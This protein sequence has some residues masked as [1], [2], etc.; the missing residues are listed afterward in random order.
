MVTLNVPMEIGSHIE[1]PT[2]NYD[3]RRLLEGR[4]FFV[5]RGDKQTYLMRR[6]FHDGVLRTHEA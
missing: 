6:D 2:W 3:L 1:I 5:E 4:G